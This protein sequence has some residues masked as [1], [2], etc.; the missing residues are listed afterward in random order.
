VILSLKQ[1][2]LLG[3]W[4]MFLFAILVDRMASLITQPVELIDRDTPLS[5]KA[6]K[7]DQH[8]A[9][10]DRTRAWLAKRQVGRGWNGRPSPR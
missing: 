5:P 9:A 10:Q 8:T 7:P 1:S 6:W 3:N 2:S 4:R